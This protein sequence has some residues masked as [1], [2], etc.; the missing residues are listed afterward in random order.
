M[1]SSNPYLAQAKSPGGEQEPV[2]WGGRD[3]AWALLAILLAIPVA[4]GLAAVLVYGL[5][6]SDAV[7]S[8]A[9]SGFIEAVLIGVALLFSI[10]KY[11]CSW[12]ALGFRGWRGLGDLG[13]VG[14]GVL[15]CLVV[16]VVYGVILR[17]LGFDDALPETPDF[18]EASSVVAALGAL[19][20]VGVAPLAEESFFRGFVFGGLRGRLGFKAAAALSA[21]LFAVA[22]LLPITFIP[23]FF[24]GLILVWVYA[25]TRSL[26]SAIQVHMGYNGI[27]LLLAWQT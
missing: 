8:L 2:P 12:A 19:L 10:V 6:V 15:A 24:I 5:D 18:V 27:V 21:A 7:L 14:A 17:G 26:W 22:H 9:I 25:R 11:R 3:I 16:S 23:I 13:L 4:V 1:G 20:A